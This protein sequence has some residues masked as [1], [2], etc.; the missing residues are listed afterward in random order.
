M[1]N[2]F[3]DS[4]DFIALDTKDIMH[5]V[6][7]E[8]LN[9]IQGI[10]QAQYDQYVN[11]QLESLSSKPISDYIKRNSLPL[12]GTPLKQ[13][14]AHQ[15]QISLLKARSDILARMYIG[16]QSREGNI[17]QFFKHKNHAFPP[18][19]SVLGKMRSTDKSK[20]LSCLV[21]DLVTVQPVVDTKVLD[22]AAIINMLSPDGRC[23]GFDQ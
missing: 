1:G 16:C 14:S 8:S 19:L 12:F 18:A 4:S 3:L 22:G 10:G 15:N 9:K 2:P 21:K 17:E 20:L 23:K 13:K 7:I 5:Q 6:V 11:E